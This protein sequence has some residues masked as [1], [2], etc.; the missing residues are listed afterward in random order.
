MFFWK[1]SLHILLCTA[2]LAS[3]LAA[4]EPSLTNQIGI[5][6]PGALALEVEPVS[7]NA[8]SSDTIGPIRQSTPSP[9]TQL[10]PVLA[11]DVPSEEHPNVPAIKEPPLL[12]PTPVEEK[13]PVAET[14]P[15]TTPAKKTEETTTAIST[16]PV[17]TPLDKSTTEML[18]NHRLI[19]TKVR[20]PEELLAFLRTRIHERNY[21][22]AAL[23]MAFTKTNYSTGTLQQECLAK[24]SQ[25]IDRVEDMY[26]Q[27]FQ[28]DSSKTERLFKTANTYVRMEFVKDSN[29]CWQ[30]GPRLIAKTDEIYDEVRDDPPIHGDW[31]SRNAPAWTHQTVWGLSYFRWSILG[32]GLLLGLLAYWVVQWLLYWL[33][34]AYMHVVYRDV[35]RQSRV[36][37]RQVA[38]IVMAFVWFR[39]FSMVVPAPKLYVVAVAVF[40]TF[41]TI[42][43]LAI[44]MKVV[45]ILAV[46]LKI[47]ILTRYPQ[48]SQANVENLI[49]PLF[50]RSLKTLLF[51]VAVISLAQAYRLPIVGVL[52]GMGIGGIALA[53][54]AKET[55]GNFFGSITV[56]ID[57]PFAIGDWIETDGVAGTVI[58]VGMRSTRVATPDSSVITIPNNCKVI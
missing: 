23:G 51:C 2:L 6:P 56:L 11:T 21:L 58:A 28:S 54:A 22:A 32:A 4:A 48:Y 29:D 42:M 14:Q 55:V 45:D 25:I 26:P 49:V 43:G 38:L 10:P 50:S 7:P 41:V 8:D 9:L 3:Y 33:M 52:S 1:R 12:D 19:L 27:E 15:D 53:F 36:V 35:T 37:W 40:A 17:E 44:M 20:N 57:Q 13:K 30:L 47:R 39:I 46:A 31:V 18:L 16:A 24:W 34:R 5:A